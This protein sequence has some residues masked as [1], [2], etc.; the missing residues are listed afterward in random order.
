MV[1]NE[2]L[3]ELVI[4]EVLRRLGL[5]QEAKP[6]GKAVVR[7]KVLAVLTGG[8]T[9]MDTA[10]TELN[11]LKANAELIVALSPAA[12]NILGPAFIREKLG[13]DVALI[14]TQSPYKGDL[15]QAVELV[16]V[17][18]L[19][20]NTA[21]KLALTIADTFVTTVIL[22]ALLRGKPVLAVADA[23]DP[24]QAQY[25]GD[26]TGKPAPALLKAL[27]DN[28]KRLEAFGVTFVS[29]RQL[30]AEAAKRIGRPK[31]AE[32]AA[33]LTHKVIDAEVVR[34]AAKRGA[35]TLTIRKGS[36]ITPLAR[37][38]A[39]GCNIQLISVTC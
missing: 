14:T 10:L 5:A 30:A 27:Q 15:L 26:R 28:L 31:D 16:L 33:V 12:E 34:A 23:T 9:G 32:A 3:V 4:A 18:V 24:H 39:R 38:I 37:D 29:S 11:M 6:A 22:Q 2:Q 25:G 8:T 1:D 20:Q 17:P 21:A 19:T 7:P 36:I 35:T 13:N